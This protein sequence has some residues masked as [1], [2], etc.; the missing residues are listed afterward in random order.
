M[1]VPIDNT[2]SLLS[3]HLTSK[4]ASSASAS[5]DQKLPP[6]NVTER[7]HPP[8]LLNES[9]RDP[10]SLLKSTQFPSQGQN[11]HRRPSYAGE[12]DA[13]AV[14]VHPPQTFP[15]YSYPDAASQQTP[16]Y[17]SNPASIAYALAP[18]QQ[19][20]APNQPQDA[21]A[22]AAAY[23]YPEAS[24]QAPQFPPSQ[25][26]SQQQNQ[27]LLPVNNTGIQAQWRHWA[28]SM[29]TNLEPQEYVNSANALMQLGTHGDLGGTGAVAA[30][31][32]ADAVALDI[33]SM[34]GTAPGLSWPNGYF[35]PDVRVEP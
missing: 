15:Q 31:N 28:G 13:A 1:R 23:L 10:H 6:L 8:Q 30:S 11:G 4:T 32:G 26:H 3:R 27:K 18:E 14:G 34:N 16:T 25:H 24:Q 7:I 2:L 5:T 12:N 29:A 20:Q 33:A 19:Q 9:F 21:A 17:L 22:T 35:G